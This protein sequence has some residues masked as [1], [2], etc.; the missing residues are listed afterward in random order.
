MWEKIKPSEALHTSQNSAVSFTGTGTDDLTVHGSSSFA[1]TR[2]YVI[3][4]DGTE[5]YKWSNDGGGTWEETAQPIF[6]GQ[7]ISLINAQGEDEGIKI[8]FSQ[9]VG[10]VTGDNWA[11]T[12]AGQVVPATATALG[13]GVVVQ[14]ADTIIIKGEYVK[15]AEDGMQIYVTLPR[16]AN[17]TIEYVPSRP[18]D[19]AGTLIH[20]QEI[21]E[22]Q[23][24]ANF[25]YIFSTYGNEFYRVYAVK[26]GVAVPTGVFTL[27]HE[28]NRQFL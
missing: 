13:T 1:T 7:Y 16:Y 5:T 8:R 12:T 22:L 24:S 10:H 14:N 27:F 23:S 28:Q 21:F 19:V 9:R 11:F 6:I 15:G 17:G 2:N 20:K 25:S 26:T 4:I 18:L 3:E